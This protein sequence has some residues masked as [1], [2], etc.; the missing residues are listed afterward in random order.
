MSLLSPR[1]VFDSRQTLFV[2]G[3]LT[4]TLAV[5]ISFTISCFAQGTPTTISVSFDF[6][7]GALGWQAG[8]ADYPPTTD[9]N[10]FY[11][12]LAEVRT[13]PPELGVNGT[14]FYIQGNN[15]SDDLFMFIKRRLNSDDGIVAGQTY[16]IT[17][18][19]VF[20]SSVQSGCVGVGGSPAV[21]LKA[22]ASPAEPIALFDSS[23][24]ISWLRMNV[25]KDPNQGNIAASPTG[26]IANGIPCGS[27]QNSYVS[28]Q[29]THQHT[30][31]VNANAKGE[32]WLL[33]G[34]DSGFEG[35]TALY[36]QRIAVTLT[37]VS[38]PPP[39]LLADDI[40]GRA[41]AV[42]SVTLMREPFSVTSPQ[43]FF[44]SDQRTRVTLFGYNLELKN[45]E[46]LSAITV[47]V[48]DSQHKVQVLPVETVEEVPNFNWI[49]G[50]TVKLPDELR[51]SGEVFV[52]IGLRGVLSN[53]VALSIK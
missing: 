1:N 35:L 13:L 28:I 33:I 41:S 37:P 42:D 20:A 48:E 53:Q 40:T 31:L 4:V 22:G 18:T 7:N 10:G 3:R 6:R 43:N 25:G 24:L 30:S 15:H 38:P 39:V 8:F 50:V 12:L 44:S 46:D 5:F 2:F 14:G 16:Q 11:Q 45:G 27:G 29:R 47:Q 17:Y 36:Y 49:K 9:K 51:G 34:T 32:L 19:L 26:T 52:K 23:P 21:T